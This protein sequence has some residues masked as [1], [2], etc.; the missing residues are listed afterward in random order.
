MRKVRL[1]RTNLMASKTAFGALPIQRINMNDAKKLLRKAYNA[2][3]NFFDTA[4]GYTDS[5]EKIGSALHDVR[6][7]MIIATKS[8]AA[9][10]T[11]LLQQL[12]T[13]LRNLRTDYVDILQL[14]N[15][16]RLPDA[17]DPESSY[18]GLL[19][20]QKKGM[21]RFLGLTS[22]MLKLAV[23]A[24][25]SGK[26]DTIQFPLSALSSK[27]ELELIDIC[28]MHDAGVIAMK[29]LCG[30]LLTNI[31]AAFSFLNQFDTVVPIWGIQ[32]EKEL[33]EFL[34]LDRDP[35]ELSQAMLSAIDNERER[36]SGDYCRG[37]GY[38]LPCPEE[39]PIPMAAR[40]TFLM[41]RA[42]TEIFITREWQEKIGRIENCRMCE[43]CIQHCPY[44]LNV[45]AILKK[46]HREY[47][48]YLVSR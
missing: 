6:H 20:A 19:E 40:I 36:L 25:T 16:S 37:C 21:V 44:E 12:E 39:I 30:G 7:E 8:G 28:K 15:P 29:A 27:E 43:H 11:T 5:E 48:E 47:Q 34:S 2:G 13:S 3:I 18:A 1:G 42:P 33:D 32:L 9:D 10:R 17:D 22:H 31:P 41:Q 46:M 24:V 38:C 35:P 26:Y 4:R 45:P 23:E 14:H